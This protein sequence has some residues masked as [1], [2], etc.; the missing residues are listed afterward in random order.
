MAGLGQVV[1]NLDMNGFHPDVL[2]MAV[3]LIG[4]GVISAIGSRT[5]KP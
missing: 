5:V 2:L 4:A 1:R 3:L